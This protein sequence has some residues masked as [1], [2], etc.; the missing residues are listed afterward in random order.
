MFS[1]V[2]SKNKLSWLCCISLV[3]SFF[4]IEYCVQC[5]YK[6]ISLNIYFVAILKGVEQFI[7]WLSY[8]PL[9]YY[10]F[11]KICFA[12]Y[13]QNSEWNVFAVEGTYKL[14]LSA[15]DSVW[16][17]CSGVRPQLLYFPWLKNEPRKFVLSYTYVIYL[18]ILL[19]R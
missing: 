8:I 13:I 14:G 10:F 7:F 16:C 17:F 11:W 4:W 6:N 2:S 12:M 19:V 5:T 3:Y 9:A 18:C 15:F 1:E